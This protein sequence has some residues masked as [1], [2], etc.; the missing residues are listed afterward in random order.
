MNGTTHQA[1]A[2]PAGVA[3]SLVQ[4]EGQPVFGRIVEA[5]GAGCAASLATRL[6]DWWDPP[7][8]SYHRSWAHS[9][10]LAV[11]GTAAAGA[12]LSDL[13]RDLRLR[14][15]WHAQAAQLSADPLVRFWHTLCE[16]FYRFLSGCLLG[17]V[18]G[19]GSHLA[20]D[21]FTPRSL[22]FIA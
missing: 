14:V 10:S 7:D 19:Y 13:Q 8:G 12:S 4:T 15:V 5:A 9:F 16:W 2:I 17:L 20:L 6:P 21:A 1:V 3:L 18:V 22:P 11:A